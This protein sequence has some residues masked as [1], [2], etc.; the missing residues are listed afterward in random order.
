MVGKRADRSVVGWVG[1]KRY[2]FP[3]VWWVSTSF[4]PTLHLLRIHLDGLPTYTL[5]NM[6]TIENGRYD[7]MFN[8]G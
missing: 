1:V 7:V 3:T 4:L 5:S 6:D 8:V 2:H